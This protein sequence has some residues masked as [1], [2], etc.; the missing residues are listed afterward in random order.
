MCNVVPAVHIAAADDQVFL[1]ALDSGRWTSQVAQLSARVTMH[2]T[3]ALADQMRAGQ[4]RGR[5]HSAELPIRG[6]TAG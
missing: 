3:A 5:M 4:T 1:W 2:I 6:C